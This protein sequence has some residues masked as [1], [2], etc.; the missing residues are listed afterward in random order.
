VGS[1]RRAEFVRI[2][3]LRTDDGRAVTVLAANDD[4]AKGWV[5]LMR[6]LGADVHNA[7]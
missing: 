2:L 6:K 5:R 4:Y 1:R 3:T 7:P